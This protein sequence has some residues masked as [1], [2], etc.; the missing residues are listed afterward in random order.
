[1]LP[2]MQRGMGHDEER[3]KQLEYALKEPDLGLRMSGVALYYC[4]YNTQLS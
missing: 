1:M 4:S 3:K 2:V